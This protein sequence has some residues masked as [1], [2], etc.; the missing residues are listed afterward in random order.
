[1]LFQTEG[2]LLRPYCILEVHTAIEAGVPI[3]ALLIRGKGSVTTRNALP[4]HDAASLL[5]AHAHE[6]TDGPVLSCIRGACDRRYDFEATQKQLTFLD[7]EL[8]SVNQGASKLLLHHGLAP[9]DAAFSLSQVVP[10]IIS[11]GGHSLSA[12]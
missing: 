3:I 11:V 4:A 12:V 9:V 1:M 8:E 5:R 7:S 10:S 6:S 2:V